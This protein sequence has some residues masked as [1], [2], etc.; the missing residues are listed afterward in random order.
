VKIVS[1]GQTGADRAA[2]D[3]A[4]DKGFEY[5]GFVPARR[6]DEDGEI[7]AICQGLVETASSSTKERTRLNIQSSDAT[8]LITHGKPRG[9]SRLTFDLA[10]ELNKPLLHIDMDAEAVADAAL[11]TR[12][13][14]ESR[15][16]RT[17]N[18]AGPR[19]SEDPEIYAAVMELLTAVFSQ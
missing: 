11:R 12:Q 19:A 18:I 13:W 4:I 1:G 8:L 2:L 14:L 16:I 6:L 5:G 15:S 9:G 3:L 10:I 7:P 17:L